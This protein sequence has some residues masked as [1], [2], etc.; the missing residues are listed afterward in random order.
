[1]SKKEPREASSGGGRSPKHS[2]AD[3][4]QQLDTMVLQAQSLVKQA[5]TSF[6]SHEERTLKDRYQLCCELLQGLAAVCEES[7]WSES[8]LL[9]RIVQPVRK[10]YAALESLKVNLGKEL[11]EEGAPVCSRGLAW[12]RE[13][14]REVNGDTDL[15][16]VYVALFQMDP[17]NMQKWTEQLHSI[18][19]ALVT[20]PVYASED[21]VKASIRARKNQECVGYACIEIPKKLLLKGAEQRTDRLNQPILSL[22]NGR[23]GIDSVR[24]FMRAGVA[25]RMRGEILQKIDNNN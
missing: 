1:M 17:D 15:M 10:T 9:E 11:S 4:V 22:T 5:V 24:Y 14:G 7:S 3:T 20:R 23:V 19:R 2:N 25:Y 16:T 13:P 21:A 18:D 8:R 6:E 12:M